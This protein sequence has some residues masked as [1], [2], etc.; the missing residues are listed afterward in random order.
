M[1]LAVVLAMQ[2]KI[3]F[4]R[5]KKLEIKLNNI[6]AKEAL[7][8]ASVIFFLAM[9]FTC[10]NSFLIV[11]ASKQGVNSNIGLFF[12]VYALTL[13]FTRP[14]VGKLTDKFGLVATGIPAIL[15]TA[16]SFY[17]ISISNS[18]PL[19]LLAA[20]VNAFGFGACQ[21]ALQSLS[22]KSVTKERR[23][24]GSS[25][26]YIGMD[27][28]TLVGPII[29][30]IFAENLGYIVMWRIMVVPLFFGLLILYIFRSRIAMIE[31]NFHEK[32]Q[33]AKEG[34]LTP[35]ADNA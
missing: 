30:G 21:P 34:N 20:F 23:G 11:Y 17:I 28:G 15:F 19:F 9:G 27:L 12:T 13:L 6:I 31:K 7:I 5:T 24:A 16:L 25:T 3:D 18:L 32:E 29:A 2:I 4:K 1:L 22:M 35:K 14:T 10:I 33:I 8:P 26:N